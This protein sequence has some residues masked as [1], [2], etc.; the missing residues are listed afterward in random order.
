MLD[1]EKIGEV[2]RTRTGVAPL[3]ISPGHRIDFA[4]AT[5]LIL[6]V[7]PKFRQPEP[8]RAAHVWVNRMRRA[9]GE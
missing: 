3:Y 1:G 8:I 7:C 6:A 2:V 4:H 9:D 5:Q